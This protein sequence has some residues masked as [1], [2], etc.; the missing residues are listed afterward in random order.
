MPEPAPEPLRQVLQRVLDAKR[1][2]RD[3]NRQMRRGPSPIEHSLL[4]LRRV[5]V[6]HPWQGT[7]MQEGMDEFSARGA[8]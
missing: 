7:P 4:A 1:L 3:G 5:R 6:V 8:S 2:L